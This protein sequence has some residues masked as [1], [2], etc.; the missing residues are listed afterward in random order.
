MESIE[1]VQ[2]HD[3]LG[4]SYIR[5]IEWN[6]MDKY[7]FFPLSMLSS[8]SVRC[9]LYPFTVIKTRLQIQKH[10]ENYS[11]TIDAFRKIFK[12]EGFGGL[13]KGFW[14]SAFQIVSGVFYITTY[15]NV[16]TFLQE[17]KIVHDS[18]MRA[19]FGGGCA[20]L[21]GQTIIVPFDVISQHVMVLGQV[22]GKNKKMMNPLNIKFKVRC[23]QYCT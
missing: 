2:I 22:Q 11:G 16:R 8:F 15:E 10:S 19:L 21:I 14:V 9:C 3:R 12:N 17:N 5:T 7:K 18:K 23:F 4:D 13:Y 6:M 1:S 20:S